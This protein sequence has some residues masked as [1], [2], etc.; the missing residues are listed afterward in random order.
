MFFCNSNI[1]IVPKRFNLVNC[2]NNITIVELKHND[3]PPIPLRDEHLELS[4]NY[5]I[6][7]DSSHKSQTYVKRISAY[8]IYV[9][10]LRSI[11]SS[12]RSIIL[13]NILCPEFETL[14]GLVSYIYKKSLSWIWKSALVRIFLNASKD[15][16]KNIPK[17][18]LAF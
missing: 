5:I 2:N 1:T 9:V 17:T 4:E 6:R 16:E 12:Y 18:T 14:T 7:S 10:A 11:T 8:S 15:T 3:L 13:T